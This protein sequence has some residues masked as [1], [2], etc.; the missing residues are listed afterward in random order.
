[1]E[2]AVKFTRAPCGKEKTQVVICAGHAVLGTCDRSC[3]VPH[4]G[5]DKGPSTL[6]LKGSILGS[7]WRT[8]IVVTQIREAR[9]GE[10]QALLVEKYLDALCVYFWAATSILTS[11][12]TFTLYALL[13]YHLTAEVVFTSLALF[14]VLIVPL[15]GFPWVSAPLGLSPCMDLRSNIATC[16]IAHISYVSQVD[17]GLHEMGQV[18]LWTSQSLENMMLLLY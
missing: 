18:A 6:G 10:L 13:G 1:M 7:V 2:H 16:I 8:A 11:I 14:N 3:V 5:L 4:E 17:G 9:E 15:N 12:I